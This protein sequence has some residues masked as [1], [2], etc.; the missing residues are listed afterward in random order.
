M[1]KSYRARFLP[2]YF[3][4]SAHKQSLLAVIFVFQLIDL[5]GVEQFELVLKILESRTT[6]KNDWKVAERSLKLARVMQGEVISYSFI[7][8]SIFSF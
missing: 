4:V 3:R 1:T 8:I 6:L 7:F 5:F 2:T